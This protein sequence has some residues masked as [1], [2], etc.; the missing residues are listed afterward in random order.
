M[1]AAA[2]APVCRRARGA[3]EQIDRKIIR[4]ED[5]SMEM[6]LIKAICED[7]TSPNA[8]SNV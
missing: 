5:Q 6:C 2:A 8:T 1:C 7:N 3:T 4:R